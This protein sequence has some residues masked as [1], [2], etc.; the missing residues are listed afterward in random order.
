MR[1]SATPRLLVLS[2]CV[3]LSA[4]AQAADRAEVEHGRLVFD[5]WCAPCHAPGPGH[6]GTA[7]LAALYRGAKPAPLEERTDLSPAV[8]RQYVRHGVSVMPFFR[9]TEI[10]DAEL[11]A[12]GT[13]LSK[14]H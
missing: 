8:V 9:K 12:L 4:L 14:Q 10:S 6:P 3:T 1:H 11:E 5:K 13:Y 2:C 7:A